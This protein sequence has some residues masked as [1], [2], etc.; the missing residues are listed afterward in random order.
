MRRQLAVVLAADICD[1]SRLM[2][3]D[4]E[5]T[6]AA[7]RRLRA[8]VFG[9]A[10]ASR[11]GRI[12][13]NMGDGWIV[14][15][16]AAADAVMCAMHVQDRL[17]EGAR[18]GEPEIRMR[19]G[20]HLGDVTEEEDDV[21]GDGINVAA[22]LE[23]AAAPEA[24]VISDAVFGSLD[25]TLRPS[26][27]DAG[28]WELKNIER[29]VQVWVRGPQ[30]AVPAAVA[31]ASGRLRLV[32]RPV[33]T[34]DDRG[35]IREMADAITGDLATYLG[36]SMWMD[37]TTSEDV[38]AADY[39]VEARLRTR[40][41]KLRLDATCKDADGTTIWTDRF[42]GDLEDSFDWQ[43]SV[44]EEVS[45][46]VLAVVFDGEHRRLQGRPVA[47]MTAAD[48]VLR[49]ALEVYSFDSD[50]FDKVL[51]LSVAAHEKDPSSADALAVLFQAL[52]TMDHPPE[53]YLSAL[54]DW[55]AR[56]TPLARDHPFLDLMLN[57]IRRRQSGHENEVVRVAERVL[58][59][60]ASDFSVLGFCGWGALFGGDPVR[61][62]DFLRR[63]MKLGRH[64]PHAFTIA[65]GLAMAHLQSGNFERAIEVGKSGLSQ[66]K[67]YPAFFR[68]LAAAHAQLG[69]M[70]EARAAYETLERLCPGDTVSKVQAYSKY[71]DTPETRRYLDG[72]KLAGMPE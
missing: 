44:A 39:V 35:E 58:R 55:M 1:Y 18:P 50:S 68:I 33:S 69:Q 28:A 29:P 48:L 53:E 25:G 4:T 71:A 8:E 38:S 47:D 17:A 54:P 64:S 31:R 22:R 65:A 56:A 51:A 42:D 11:R 16:S 15:F 20:V 60:N 37:A 21:F 67:A 43:D 3:E 30:A 61:G 9:P 12:V 23:A 5:A 70:D 72:L 2:A 46:E 27:D 59:R 66:H 41:D 13:K 40:G 45:A 32:V 52:I 63:A 10:V 19:V 6:L 26:F 24:V 14:L 34:S 49:A 62:G 7:L 36:A 57:E